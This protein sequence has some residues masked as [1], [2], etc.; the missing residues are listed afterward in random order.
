MKGDREAFLAA[1]MD[2]RIAKP[3]D[4]AELFRVPAAAAARGHSRSWPGLPFPRAG[5]YSGLAR[6]VFPGAP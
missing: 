1:G 3:V 4:M 6:R 5:I 2:G